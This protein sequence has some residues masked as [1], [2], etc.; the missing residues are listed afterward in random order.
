VSTVAALTA[1]EA[2]RATG[3]IEPGSLGS[4]RVDVVTPAPTHDRAALLSLTRNGN[5]GVGES[6]TR[7]FVGSSM[8]MSDTPDEYRDHI[9]AIYQAHGRVLVHGLGLGCY[10]RAILTKPTVEHVDVV[11]ANEDVLAYIGPSFASDSRVNLLHGDAL[12]FRWP[13]GERW[14]VVWHDIWADK[15]SDNL[16]EYARLNR[17]FGRRCG[18]QG[19]WALEQIR[20]RRRWEREQ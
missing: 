1:R 12:T 6:Y 11:E 17:R 9:T 5:F 3:V 8:V 4:V 16:P 7:L 19:A 18:W 13:A 14:D 15:C 20:A 2:F 10:L